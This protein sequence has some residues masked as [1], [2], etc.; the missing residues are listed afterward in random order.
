MINTSVRKGDRQQGKLEVL[1]LATN[2]CT[3]TLQLCRNE[4][5]FP[6]S[7]RWI[8]T[9]KIANEAVDALACIRR[10]NATLV[11]GEDIDERHRYRSGQQTEAHAHLGALYAL[12]DIAYNMNSSIDGDRVAYWTQL[13]M[14]TDDKL[15][16]WARANNNDYLGKKKR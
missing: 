5:L 16:A 10:A 11:D 8:L 3:H 7:Q 13:I 12:V 6:K 2:L 15:K 1:N 14:D 9:Q 4:K